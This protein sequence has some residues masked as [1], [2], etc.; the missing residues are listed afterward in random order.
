MPKRFKRINITLPQEM[1]RELRAVRE[2][3]GIPI[4][5]QLR[6]GFE[7]RMKRKF[8]RGIRERFP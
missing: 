6:K 7:E 5:T 2:R 3:E 4:S 1:V 8:A